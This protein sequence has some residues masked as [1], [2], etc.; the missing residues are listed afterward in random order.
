M[1]R[2][3]SLYAESH[4]LGMSIFRPW[5]SNVRT[6]RTHVLNIHQQLHSK[7]VTLCTHSTQAVGPFD[8]L[9]SPLLC[10]LDCTSLILVFFVVVEY[11]GLLKL[12]TLG[13]VFIGHL[14]DFLLILTQVVGPADR[15]GYYAPFYGPLLT[16]VN[17]T[18]P[19]LPAAGVTP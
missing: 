16:E 8:T 2:A 7:C 10:T 3:Y 14:I 12:C 15:S 9:F 19:F 5:T 18:D 6:Q 11:S 1:E 17:T 4:A 13:F